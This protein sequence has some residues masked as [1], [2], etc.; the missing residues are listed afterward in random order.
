MS[1]A[2]TE[3]LDI[4]GYF[5]IFFVVIVG[6]LILLFKFVIAYTNKTV[7]VL[8][9]SKHRDAEFIL[10]TRHAPPEWKK[11]IVVHLGSAVAKGYAIRRVR[12]IADYFKHT[13]LID[14]EE[15]RTAAVSDLKA[16]R[17]EWRDTKWSEIF[18]YE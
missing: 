10:N 12:I 1:T 3:A 15:A 9:E 6:F 4:V 2:A 13:P 18:P 7:S 8:V 5:F 16:I 14:S 17:I 11:K